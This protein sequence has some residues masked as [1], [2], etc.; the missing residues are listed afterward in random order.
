MASKNNL[1]AV[2]KDTADALREKSGTSSPIVPRDF[3]TFISSMPSGGSD[4]ASFLDG[5]NYLI[6]YHLTLQ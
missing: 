3:A 2:L 5:R 4:M 1:R 6:T